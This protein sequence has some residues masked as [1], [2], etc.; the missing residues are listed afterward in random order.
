MTNELNKQEQEAAKYIEKEVEP[1]ATSDFKTE[2][3]WQEVIFNFLKKQALIFVGKTL[4]HLKS[5]G[6]EWAVDL[7]D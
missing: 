1:V 4:E 7:A 6:I 3:L 2:G 5:K